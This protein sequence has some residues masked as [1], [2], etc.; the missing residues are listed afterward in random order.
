MSLTGIYF[1]LALSRDFPIIFDSVDIFIF[2]EY[3][4]NS[5]GFLFAQSILF[6]NWPTKESTKSLLSLKNSDFT[7]K[8]DWG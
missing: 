1:K 3:A 5:S 7:I 4:P 2:S 8:V 6:D